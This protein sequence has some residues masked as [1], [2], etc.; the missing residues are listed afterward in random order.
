VFA[1]LKTSSVIHTQSRKLLSAHAWIWWCAC[2]FAKAE[3]GNVKGGRCYFTKKIA[4]TAQYRGIFTSTRAAWQ[5]YCCV[6]SCR[7]ISLVRPQRCWFL[8]HPIRVSSRD[9]ETSPR[10]SCGNIASVNARNVSQMIVPVSAITAAAVAAAAVDPA[11]VGA[12]APR[13]VFN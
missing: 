12:D 6:P 9:G 1:V 13:L 7:G 3:P 10:S 11:A 2:S 4:F 5:L 8:C